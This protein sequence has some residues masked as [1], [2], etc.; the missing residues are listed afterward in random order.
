MTLIEFWSILPPTSLRTVQFFVGEGS[1]TLKKNV[2][3]LTAASK[4]Y[5]PGKICLVEGFFVAKYFSC[6]HIL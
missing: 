3:D 6:H 4:A 1:T 2:P 5:L